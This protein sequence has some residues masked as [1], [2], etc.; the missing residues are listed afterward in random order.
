MLKKPTSLLLAALITL[1]LFAQVR[2]KIDIPDIDGYVTLK[3]DFH[4]HTVFS[5]GLVWPTVRVDE[6]YR[7]GLDAIAI[8]DHIEYRPHTDIVASHNRSYEIA[9]TKAEEKGII[10]IRGSEITRKMPPGHHNALFITDAD[11]LEHSE[12]IDA[13]RA[14]KAQNAFIVWNNP[15]WAAQQPDTT[16]WMAE[17]TQLFEQ[18]MM[19]GI[20]VVNRLYC[21]ESHQWCLDKKLTMMGNSDMHQPIQSDVDFCT[22]KHR[23]MTLVFAKSAT[24][25]D[26]REALSERRTA[27]YYNEYVIGEEKYLKEIFE[28]AL[29][30]KIEKTDS[31][32]VR[33]TVKNCSDLTFHLKKRQHDTRLAY[34]R[35][36]T[37]VPHGEHSL[38]VKLRDGAK[39]GE[40]NFVVENFLTL[41]NEGMRCS[42]KIQ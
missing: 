32:T 35:E 29:E 1:P 4:I 41:P 36:T 40:L 26:I 18:G 17:H 22:G 2:G 13:F 10:L 34:F 3:C 37:I 9:Q 12:Y 28:K 30:W 20:E 24:V 7:E 14:A 31:V 42:V 5:D 15:H 38:I 8:T 6:A 16:L 23:T 19:H 25:E 33:I 27:V 39:D 21:P 11:S